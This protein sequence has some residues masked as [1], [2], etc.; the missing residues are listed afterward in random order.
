MTLEELVAEFCHL[1]LAQVRDPLS[2]CYDDQAEID[3]DIVVNT[4]SSVRSANER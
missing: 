1:T 3:G 2:Y 4:E